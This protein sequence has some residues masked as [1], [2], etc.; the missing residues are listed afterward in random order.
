MLGQLQ[1]GD[2]APTGKCSRKS[3]GAIEA[4]RNFCRLPAGVGTMFLL[5]GDVNCVE[6][7]PERRVRLAA[8][9]RPEG[10]QYRATLA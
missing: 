4:E 3:F 1:S 8:M 2:P 6:E 5:S 9:L 10:E 7:Q